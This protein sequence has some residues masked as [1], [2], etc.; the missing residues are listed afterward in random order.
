MCEERLPICL[1]FVASFTRN[2]WIYFQ[3]Q[4]KVLFGGI[5]LGHMN[6]GVH[7]C[8]KYVDR[9]DPSLSNLTG[10]SIISEQVSHFY[11]EDRGSRFC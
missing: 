3:I 1:L 6:C 8:E 5:F 7:S 11:S 9:P 4:I 2:S 10:S